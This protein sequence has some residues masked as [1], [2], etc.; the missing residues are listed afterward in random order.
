MRWV[1]GEES[2]VDLESSAS[3]R[4]N[5][6]RQS[7]AGIQHTFHSTSG[8]EIGIPSREWS[9]HRGFGEQCKVD[10]LDKILSLGKHQVYNQLC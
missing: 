8:T 9:I 1:P 3:E 5:A 6:S 2:V 10:L 7:D 4:S